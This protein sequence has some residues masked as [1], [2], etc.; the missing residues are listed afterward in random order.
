[1]NIFYK[2]VGGNV[3]P[4]DIDCTL[5]EFQNMVSGY[6]SYYQ[7]TPE[8]AVVCNDSGAQRGLPYNCTIL[9]SKFYGNVFLIGRGRNGVYGWT[10]VKI[11]LAQ[12]E[13]LCSGKIKWR[14]ES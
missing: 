8:L 5:E 3:F 4:A 14:D 12:A 1:M 13:A 10:D 6:F 11:T 9:N 7:I 2:P